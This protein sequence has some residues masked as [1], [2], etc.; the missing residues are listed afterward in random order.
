ME[1]SSRENYAEF[2]TGSSCELDRAFAGGGAALGYGSLLVLSLATS[3]G[4]SM[5]HSRTPY[6]VFVAVTALV[7]AVAVQAADPL[8]RARPEDVGMSAERLASLTPVL[9]GY[10]DRQQLAGSVALVARRGKL[11][12]YE[13]FGQQDREARAPMQV[14]SIFRIASQ[15]K[16]IVTTAAMILVEQ[17][18]LGLND[19]IARYIPE[20][21]EAKVAVPKD[22]GGYYLETLKRPITVRDLMTHTS[23]LSYGNGPAAAEWQKA[24]M[25]WAPRATCA[26][27]SAIGWMW[28]APVHCS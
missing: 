16:A 2:A 3:L 15:S 27:S 8:P 18:K 10:V 22:G 7:W 17:G 21:A 4:G 24:G 5:R 12:Y 25:T 20:F 9:K 23:G 6:A 26:S 13:A 14:D 19:P 11:V 28:T 1:V